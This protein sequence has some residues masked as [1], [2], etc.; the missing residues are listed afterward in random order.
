M[1]SGW[2][3]FILERFEFPFEVVYPQ[4][5]NE[6]DLIE[7]FDA[8]IFVTGAI[9]AD[10]RGGGGMERRMFGPPPESIPEEYREWLGSVTVGE[11]VPRLLEF[12]E[13]GGT[14][15]AIGSSTCMARH[16]NLAVTNH[17]VDGDGVSLGEDTYY[18][19]GSVLRVEVDNDLP[20]AYG[21]PEEMDV[22][23]N[24]SPVVR[25]IPAASDRGVTPV[26]W[27]NS[28]APLRS[29]WAWGQ[30]YLNGGVAIAE[31]R[32]GRGNLYLFGAEIANRGQPHGTFK[33]LFNG[34]F[35]SGVK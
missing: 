18:V 24:N 11:T 34:L 10:G 15:L 23:F 22:F 12:L 13:A 26:A 14:I 3:R 20:L 33:F 4:T 25:M 28:D 17:L 27:F 6:P 9:P 7:R 29:G 8:L 32:V 19:P 35:L 16:A 21:T 2:T 30:H 1:P 31:A 5:L